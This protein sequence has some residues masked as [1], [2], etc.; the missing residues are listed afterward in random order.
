MKDRKGLDKSGGPW[1]N[2]SVVLVKRCISKCLESERMGS[3]YDG[4]CR[5]GSLSYS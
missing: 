4:E 2:L 1:Y 3:N 5:S